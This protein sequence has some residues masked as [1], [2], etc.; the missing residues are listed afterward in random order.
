MLHSPL[1]RQSLAAA[2]RPEFRF[3]WL[4]NSLANFARWFELIVLTWMVLGLTG[5]PWQLAVIGFWRNIPLLPIGP[6]GG[7]L[8]DLFD[9]RQL[10][11]ATQLAAGVVSLAIAALLLAGA[12]TYEHLIATSIVLGLIAAI[13]W[14]C[15]RVLI[16][17]TVPREEV[18]NAAAL[19]SVSTMASRVFGPLLG[20]TL[21]ALLGASGC[22]VVLA[23]AYTAAGLAA[24]GLRPVPPHGRA[25]LHRAARDLGE[26]VHYALRQPMIYA[27]LIAT[28][29]SNLLP[30][31]FL[32]FL[33][34]FA[35]DVLQ[36]D[37]V[38]YGTLGSAV[39]VGALV[40]ATGL[41]TTAQRW[42]PELAFLTGALAMGA[43]LIPFALT[44]SY[45]I[46][47]LCLLAFGFGQGLYASLQAPVILLRV[48]P[49][50]RGRLMGLL[51]C[52][53]GM[54]PVGMLLMGA[55]IDRLGAPLAVVASAGTYVVLLAAIGAYVRRL[56]EREDRLAAA[57][58][59]REGDRR[60]LVR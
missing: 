28:F 1:L 53:I 52:A 40:S 24:I 2:R 21:L 11:I 14:P 44:S 60:P 41:A 48:D 3:L 30:L 31:P 7:L 18:V 16:I 42:R 39:G 36:L 13:D 8:G 34:V 33:P 56:R 4:A 55:L 5:S 38:R 51:I 27:M 47:L 15:R 32:Q 10:V 45:G 23:V 12:L 22:Y 20:G 59:V 19:D 37:P 6:F 25:T 43:S 35:R 9:R 17:D 49:A 54:W 26:G 46:A 50:L 58:A 29:L 57:P